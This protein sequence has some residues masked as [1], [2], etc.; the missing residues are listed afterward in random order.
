MKSFT[1]V[2][3]VTP[4][5]CC[6]A[7]GEMSGRKLLAKE[8]PRLPLSA[9]TMPGECRCRF[10]KHSD[11]RSGDDD[12]RLFSSSQRSV[13]YAGQQRRNSS[14]RRSDDD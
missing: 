2:S 5:S 7:V 4:T 12:R 10:Q 11:R 14:G 13:W 6:P 3:I 8:A 1:A 9:C